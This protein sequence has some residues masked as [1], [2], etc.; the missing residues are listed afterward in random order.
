MLHSWGH[1]HLGQEFV[2]RLVRLESLCEACSDYIKGA[3][4]VL[5][6]VDYVLVVSLGQLHSLQHR[7][8]GVSVAHS[9]TGL[10]HG[11]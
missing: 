8:V 6:Y 7:V 10:K 1:H 5:P 3:M 4:G 11:V 9:Q 2:L